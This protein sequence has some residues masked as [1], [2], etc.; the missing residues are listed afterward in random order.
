MAKQVKNDIW[1]QIEDKLTPYSSVKLK[2]DEHEIT[3]QYQLESKKMKYYIVVFIDGVVKWGKEK[4]ELSEKF[5]RAETISRYKPKDIKELEKINGKRWIKKNSPEIYKKRTYYNPIFS[6][7][8]SL[9]YQWKKRGLKPEFLVEKE[10]TT[11]V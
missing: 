9:R 6:T 11:D 5:W 2:I 3:L 7:F 1:K 8:G 10:E 4:P